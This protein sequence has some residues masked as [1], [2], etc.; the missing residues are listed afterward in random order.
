MPK[1]I[2]SLFPSKWCRTI[3]YT[4]ILSFPII[5]S[6]VRHAAFFPLNFGS[7]ILLSKLMHC[8][9]Y[10]FIFPLHSFILKTQRKQ[11]KL[12][13]MVLIFDLMLSKTTSFGFSPFCRFAGVRLKWQLTFSQCMV[14]PEEELFA[15]SAHFK[16]RFQ[17]QE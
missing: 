6:Q 12:F 14:E 8:Y 13:P 17:I 1:A 16:F 3:L 15:S 7:V 4:D 2:G 5:V 9:L 10:N 11:V